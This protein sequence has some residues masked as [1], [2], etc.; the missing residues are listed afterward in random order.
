VACG[1]FIYIALYAKCFN[2][3]LALKPKVPISWCGLPDAYCSFYSFN[4]F[5]KLKKFKNLK[6][7]RSDQKYCKRQQL[8][9]ST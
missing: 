2:L 9:L 3:K 8:F 5:K 7:L 1:F 4:K 6:V